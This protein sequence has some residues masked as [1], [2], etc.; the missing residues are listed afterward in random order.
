VRVTGSD[1]DRQ[2][3]AINGASVFSLSAKAVSLLP[4]DCKQFIPCHGHRLGSGDAAEP[5][6]GLA[7]IIRDPLR[8]RRRSGFALLHPTEWPQSPSFY[9]AGESSRACSASLATMI[10]SSMQALAR[11]DEVVG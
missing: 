8:D 9:L 5:V 1:D 3:W 10:S 2:T 11:A 4:R 6:V 7:L